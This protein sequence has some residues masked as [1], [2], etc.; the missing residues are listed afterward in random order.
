MDVYNNNEQGEAALP[1]PIME[2][3]ERASERA[4]IG[5]PRFVT[6]C[7]I[8]AFLIGIGMGGA[9]RAFRAPPPWLI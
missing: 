5:G 1:L 8:A 2:G 3:I 7:S 6:R 9:R 4:I